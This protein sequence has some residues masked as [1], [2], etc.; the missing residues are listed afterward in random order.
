MLA[1]LSTHEEATLRKI[2]FGSDDSLEPVHL[3]RL[4]DL[5]LIACLPSV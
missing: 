4:L 5:Q 3:R 1:R 2:G